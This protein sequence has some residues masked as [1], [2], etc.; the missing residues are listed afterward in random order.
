MGYKAALRADASL[1]KGLNVLQGKLVCKAVAE[2]VGM[3]YVA[4]D[5]SDL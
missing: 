5:I 4:S 1:A 3:D 2:G